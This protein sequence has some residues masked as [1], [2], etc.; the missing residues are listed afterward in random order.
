[1]SSS[2][3]SLEFGKLLPQHGLGRSCLFSPGVFPV[4]RLLKLKLNSQPNK[5]FCIA[6]PQTNVKAAMGPADQKTDKSGIQRLFKTLHQGDYWNFYSCV[7]RLPLKTDLSGLNHRETVLARVVLFTCIILASHPFSVHLWV[8]VLHIFVWTLAF[9]SSHQFLRRY[10]L[11]L[12]VIVLC[13]L[14]TSVYL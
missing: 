12:F 10:Q 14:C 1:M 11:D 2:V 13:F 9:L 5:A 7:L 3:Q 8:Y 4:E 6:Q